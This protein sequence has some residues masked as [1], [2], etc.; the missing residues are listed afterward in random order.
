MPHTVKK[1]E[2]LAHEINER[3]IKDTSH[4]IKGGWSFGTSWIEG[5]IVRHLGVPEDADDHQ[6]RCLVAS[7]PAT[8]EMFL[9]HEKQAALSN[10]APELLAACKE[11]VAYMDKLDADAEPG[12]KITE[13][14][15]HYHAARVERTRAAIA[16]AEGK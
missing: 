16:A 15:R 8:N 2:Q 3:L 5:M 14:R 7:D 9:N 13:V 1:V 4:L 10:A 12:D 11:W 6:R